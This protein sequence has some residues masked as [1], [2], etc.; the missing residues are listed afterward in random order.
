MRNIISIL[1]VVALAMLASGCVYQNG[2]FGNPYYSTATSNANTY[3]IQK[4]QLRQ[5]YQAQLQLLNNQEHL[6]ANTPSNRRY[7]NE[8][9]KLL[10]MQYND[11][12]KRINEAE[13]Q[14]RRIERENERR[15]RNSAAGIF[16]REFQNEKNRF[17]R[18][19][20][21]NAARDFFR[22]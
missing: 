7:F 20:A 17:V 9:R 12:L 11:N 10:R 4:D 22:Y 15:Y 16:Q 21:R 14:Q 5:Q 18:R 8:Q 19:A 3:K 6:K 1:L 13:R 2:G